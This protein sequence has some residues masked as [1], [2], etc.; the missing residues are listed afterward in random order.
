MGD[1]PATTT[2]VVDVVD[3][4]MLKK[5]SSSVHGVF[6]YLATPKLS[7]LLIPVSDPL[8]FVIEHQSRAPHETEGAAG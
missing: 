8:I 4:W 1:F 3:I 6:I 2:S 7:P 5:G